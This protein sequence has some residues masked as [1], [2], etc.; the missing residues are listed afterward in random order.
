M[1][2]SLQ[3]PSS[4]LRWSLPTTPARRPARRYCRSCTNPPTAATR[5][6]STTKRRGSGKYSQ[7]TIIICI[8]S[9]IAFFETH[10]KIGGIAR[11]NRCLDCETV[12][13]RAQVVCVTSPPR[14]SCSQKSAE[15]KWDSEKK[16]K[17]RTDKRQWGSVVHN[18]PLI[19][20]L[21]SHPPLLSFH[22]CS[23]HFSSAGQQ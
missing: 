1:D 16:P 22:I 20:F 15:T 12:T 7:S 3:V 6:P 18:V 8:F 9:Y 17:R 11:Q 2:R 14:N 5:D 19:S 13:C 10:I 4:P 21:I 23:F